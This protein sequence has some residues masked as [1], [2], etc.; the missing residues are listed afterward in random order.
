MRQD[1]L[2]DAWVL[3]SPERRRRPSY[4]DMPPE[5][6]VD[7][8]LC[9]F[10]EGNEGLTPPEI[11]AWRPRGGSSRGPGWR[12][13]VFA[14][15]FP[16]LRVE[17]EPG[18]AAEGR[19]ITLNGVGAHEVVAETPDHDAW[20]GDMDAAHLG[21]LF[22]AFKRRIVDL[23]GDIRLKYI[24]VF[25]NHGRLAAATI[26]HPH[27]QILA[28][29]VVPAAVKLRLERARKIFKEDG[30]CYFCAG[31]GNGGAAA[32]RKLLENDR[33]IILAPFAPLFPFEVRLLPKTH[34]ARFEDTPA[35]D[36]FALGEI[37][38]DCMGRVGRC[39]D[40]PALQLMLHNAPFLSKCEKY[41]HWHLD[42]VPRIAGIGGFEIATGC[43]INAFSPEETVEALKRF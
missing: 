14:N 3:I 39:L 34:R 24:Q 19:D 37:L 40:R 41:Y 15:K 18:E 16:A 36:F 4:I 12:V 17:G 6:G 8:D 25:K 23:R 27:S 31:I 42:I 20:M 26:P 43:Y 28:L 30:G 29:P 21:E 5:Q 1:P 7:P 32:K 35:E 38:K 13:R 22:L 9:P 11:D 2:T 33:F 10:C